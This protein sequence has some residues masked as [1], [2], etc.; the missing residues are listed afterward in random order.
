MLG[1]SEVSL[2]SSTL[3]K[4]CFSNRA[5]NCTKIYGLNLEQLLTTNI[6]LQF[7]NYH[8]DDCCLDLDKCKSTPCKNGATC[9]KNEGTFTCTCKAGFTGKLCEQG[10][11][12][13]CLC[14]Q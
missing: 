9:V 2:E 1:Y 11:A 7:F 3:L 8:I 13:K 12:K 6:S 4:N 5:L 14:Y 10:T